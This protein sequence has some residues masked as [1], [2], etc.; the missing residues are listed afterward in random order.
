MF[1]PTP[2]NPMRECPRPSRLI[3]LCGSGK[4]GFI[5]FARGQGK[6]VK[7]TRHCCTDDCTAAQSRSEQLLTSGGFG[8]PKGVARSVLCN[9][10]IS[11]KNYGISVDGAHLPVTVSFCVSFWTKLLVT[12]LGGTGRH[13]PYGCF[14][15][16]RKGN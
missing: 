11:H 3:D 6:E 8:P 14:S 1:L 10:L 12:S 9:L 16:K 2:S 15:F 4:K 7:Q 5:T 13:G